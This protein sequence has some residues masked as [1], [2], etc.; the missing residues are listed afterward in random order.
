MW[1]SPQRPEVGVVPSPVLAAGGRCG[2]WVQ[3]KLVLRRMFAGAVSAWCH[4]Q[5]S[6]AQRADLL[7]AVLGLGSDFP[8]AEHSVTKVQCIVALKAMCDHKDAAR[9]LVPGLG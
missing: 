6:G 3:K 4:G 2:P 5:Q 1:P 8:D 9:Y 7:R